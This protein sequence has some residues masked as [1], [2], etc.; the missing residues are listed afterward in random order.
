MQS[1]VSSLVF[2][3]YIATARRKQTLEL[4]FFF[5][6]KKRQTQD[7]QLKPSKLMF[8]PGQQH[9]EEQ[10]GQKNRAKRSVCLLQSSAKI[11]Q[12]PSTSANKTKKKGNNFAFLCFSSTSPSRHCGNVRKRKQGGMNYQ[13]CSVKQRAAIRRKQ[14]RNLTFVE[15]RQKAAKLCVWCSHHTP[16]QTNLF[17][18]EKKKIVP[19]PI[20]LSLPLHR[21]KRALASSIF[22]TNMK[23][24]AHF[25]TFLHTSHQ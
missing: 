7:I 18:R 5:K 23:S 16:W 17:S 3:I 19:S 24:W 9:N 8:S 20:F 25:R 13:N 11:P 15:S 4:M 22:A 14:S 6:K 21:T 10:F 12:I 1:S 2:R